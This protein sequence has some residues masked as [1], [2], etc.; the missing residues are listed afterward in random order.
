MNLV[1]GLFNLFYL[2]YTMKKKKE[3]T[4]KEYAEKIDV[5][6]ATVYYWILAG[7]QE[8]KGFSVRKFGKSYVI[9]V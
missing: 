7:L 5:P 1:L 4:I 3:Y 8:K 2:L 9:E 6:Y